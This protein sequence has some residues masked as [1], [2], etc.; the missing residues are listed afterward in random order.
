VPGVVRAVAAHSPETVVMVELDRPVA[1]HVRRAACD[2]GAVDRPVGMESRHEVVP[3]FTRPSKSLMADVPGI[4]EYVL[5]VSAM[6]A[7]ADLVIDILR[8]AIAA[9]GG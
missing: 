2:L 5:R 8:Q 4:E 3:C 9:A 1:E 6:R 7:G